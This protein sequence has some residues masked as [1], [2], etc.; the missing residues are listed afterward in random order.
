MRNEP[1]PRI[2]Q[3]SRKWA[4]SEEYSLHVWVLVIY[5]GCVWGGEL[6]RQLLWFHA[7]MHC[8]PFASGLGLP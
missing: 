5:A 4:M 6:N 1:F 8:S 2:L 3:H 7:Q